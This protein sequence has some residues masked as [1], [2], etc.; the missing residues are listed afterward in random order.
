[1]TLRFRFDPTDCISLDG[2]DYLVSDQHRDG[3]VLQQIDN[4]TI[5]RPLTMEEVATLLAAPTTRLRR[6]HL[7]RKRSLQRLHHEHTYFSTLPEKKRWKAA[8]GCWYCVEF[9]SAYMRQEVQRT[10]ASIESFMPILT[11]RVNA[12][13]VS[14][15]HIG[16]TKRVGRKSELLDPPSP[17]TLLTWVRRYERH[18]RDPLALVRKQ[19]SDTSYAARYCPET[20]KLLNECLGG[21]L[22]R[23]Q[24]P[25]AKIARDVKDCFHDENAR[26]RANG[27]PTLRVPSER[28]V[29][30][31]LARLGKLIKKATRRGADETKR[32][33][34]LYENGVTVFHPL[35]RVEIDEWPIDVFSLFHEA[36]CLDDLEEAEK[37]RYNVG[38]RYLY[39]AIDVAT[40]CV[41]GFL[42]SAQPN[43]A[44]AIRTLALV[45]RDKTEIAR[46]TGC[47]CAWDFYGG[48]GSI[49]HD[50]G[51]AFIA[52]EF[53]GTATDL[54]CTQMATTAGVPKLRA[55][56]E[57]VF[58][59]FASQLMPELSGRSFSNVQQLG[60]YPGEKLAALTDD[61]LAKIFTL[62]IVD[63]YHNSKHAGLNEETPA[64]AWRR[65]AG[66]QG[67]V[68][69]PDQTT[70][71]AAFGIP[72]KHK[73]GR[74]GLRVFG[75]DYSCPELQEA[76]L[77]GDWEP[78]PVRVDPNDLTHVSVFIVDE[79]YSAKAVSEAVWGM[80]LEG[81]REVVQHIRLKHRQEVELTE[82]IVIRARKKIRK[83]NADAMAR[84]RIKPIDLTARDL[85]RLERELFLGLSI[86]PKQQQA[87]VADAPTGA[88]LLGDVIKPAP[89]QATEITDP[90][91]QK[92]DT[93]WEFFDE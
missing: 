54:G 40:R 19:R 86:K 35:Q 80:T 89:R 5:T 78:I 30:R 69:A 32:D 71:C 47:E 74:H 66:E 26:R 82:E 79:W 24:P 58:L 63:I 90:K 3:V 88:G 7:S 18:G 48:I 14:V 81:W 92:S 45:T 4:P 6:G 68:S 72:A 49:V 43:S 23:R 70:W 8:W 60:D 51:S 17:R 36:G 73:V 57:R 39:L 22:S 75:I 84:R 38:R 13:S 16:T 61:D 11:Q 2:V 77:R 53:I 91:Q 34:A 44:D 20:V 76:Y 55:H 33:M 50:Q 85:E 46:A 93:G 15:Q 29:Y 56:V 62:F 64:N 12:R 28:E 21:Y 87:P 59:T 52:P 25:K 10:E 27:L 1:M 31:R 41:V 42:I 83:I 67:V 37:A 9:L 65:L